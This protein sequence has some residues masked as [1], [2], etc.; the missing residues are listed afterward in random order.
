M[1]LNAK[2]SGCIRVGPRCDAKCAAITTSDGHQIPWIKE[3]RYLGVYIVQ[4]RNFKGV[5]HEHKKAFF[6]S[7]N[8][9]FG[10]IGR[11]ASED[12]ILQLLFSKCVPVLLYG[13]EALPL[14]KSDLSSLDFSYNRFL[15]KL[16]RTS[17]IDVIYECQV[18]FGI[19]LPSQLLEERRSSFFSCYNK[20]PNCLYNYFVAV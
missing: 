20:S 6:R 10:K 16:F 5:T 2:K 17:N 3:L 19:K 18:Y 9:I 7:V 14:N 13:L 15:M 1:K 11:I 4:S 8:A 12:V